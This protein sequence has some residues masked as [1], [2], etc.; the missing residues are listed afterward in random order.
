MLLRADVLVLFARL[1]LVMTSCNLLSRS[2]GTSRAAI[3]VA[4]VAVI[5]FS[6]LAILATAAT[7]AFATRSSLL[8]HLALA[9]FAVN[10]AFVACHREEMLVVGRWVRNNAAK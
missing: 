1:M 5:A 4:L 6:T 9:L 7:V 10:V 3:S 2:V 8:G